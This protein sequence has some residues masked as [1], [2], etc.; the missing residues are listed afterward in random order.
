MQDPDEASK[1]PCQV[2]PGFREG[3]RALRARLQHLRFLVVQDPD[4]ASKEPRQF[5]PEVTVM[6]GARPMH[7]EFSICV[8]LDAG[9][10]C[11]LQG[12]KPIRAGG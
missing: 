1:V 10:G 6:V 8:L 5:T 7:A 12:T 3:A 9:P 4:A 2:M 11:G